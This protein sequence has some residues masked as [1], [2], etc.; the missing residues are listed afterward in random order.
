MMPCAGHIV[1]FAALKPPPAVTDSI[2]LA[3]STCLRLAIGSVMSGSLPAWL[4]SY[5]QALADE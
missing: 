1:S 3:G 2:V 5:A 4:S